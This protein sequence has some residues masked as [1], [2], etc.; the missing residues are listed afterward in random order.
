M[1]PE[2]D[3]SIRSPNSNARRTDGGVSMLVLHYTDTDDARQSLDILTSP[4][5]E[6]SAHYLIGEDGHVWNLVPE[7]ERAWHAGAGRWRGLDDINSRSIGIELQNPGH[8]HGYRAFTEPQLAA[9]I[10]LCQ[11]I[12]GRHAIAPRDVIAHSDLAPT[13]KRDPGELFPWDR[14]AAAGIGLFPRPGAAGRVPDFLAGLRAFGYD[15]ADAPAAIAAFQRRFATEELGR[16]PG[17]A[18]H[19]ALA[20]L[21]AQL[22]PAPGLVPPPPGPMP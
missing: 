6:V 5:R 11:G 14:L 13:R 1:A 9:L 22:R 20:D 8:G 17:P 16:P 15:T 7:D 21:L 2:I 12:L 3:R 18:A 10:A 4:A 19:A